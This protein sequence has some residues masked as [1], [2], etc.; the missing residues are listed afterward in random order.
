[1]IKILLTL[2][3]FSKTG[4]QLIIKSSLVAGK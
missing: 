1:M 2:H 4:T 3:H